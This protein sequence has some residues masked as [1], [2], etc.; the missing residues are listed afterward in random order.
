MKVLGVNFFLKHSVYIVLLLLPAMSGT[1]AA[2]AKAITCRDRMLY[3]QQR[4][5]IIKLLLEVRTGTRSV[6]ILQI[7]SAVNPSP[8]FLEKLQQAKWRIASAMVY[9]KEDR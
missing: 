1:I 9:A 2:S 3:T 8:P 5:E 4:R 7:R 6:R